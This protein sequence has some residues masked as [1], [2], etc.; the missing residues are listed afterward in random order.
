MNLIADLQLSDKGQ[1]LLRSPETRRLLG[2]ASKGAGEKTVRRLSRL[3]D[4]LAHSQDI[5]SDDWEMILQL[6][7][8]VE[9]I[10]RLGSVF[11]ARRR[12]HPRRRRKT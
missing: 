9:G 1:L 3:R 4:N 7:E 2:F 5:V 12:S 10:M 11:P 8:R 6:A